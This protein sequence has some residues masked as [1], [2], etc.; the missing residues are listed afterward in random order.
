MDRQAL[1]D[2]C[3]AFHGHACG[4]LTIGFQAARYAMELLELDFS[5]DEDVVCIAE[6]DACGVDA[7]QA[8][9]S[10]TIGKGNLLYRGTGKQAFSFFNRTTGEK[11]RMCMKPK[12]HEMDRETYMHYLLDAPVEEIFEFSVPDFD[13]PEKARIFNT[14][15]CELCGEGAPEHKM[16]LQEGKKVC[17]DCF[18]P[19]NRG[20]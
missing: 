3:V 13:L 8:I 11:I 5:A 17:E 14:I 12:N 6:N 4:G 16:H 7:V 10:C 9:L 19:Y 15:Y 20:W 1:W 2:K 18:K